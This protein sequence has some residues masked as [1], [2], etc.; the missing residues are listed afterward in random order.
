MDDNLKQTA[1]HFLATER[2]ERDLKVQ[3]IRKPFG[4]NLTKALE[5]EVSGHEREIEAIDALVSLVEKE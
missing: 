2:K 3:R 4:T 1:L 5:A